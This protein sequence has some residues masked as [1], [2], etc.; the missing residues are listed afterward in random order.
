L[1]LGVLM[2]DDPVTRAL[3]LRT[4]SALEAGF[5]PLPIDQN[6]ARVFA[7]IVAEARRLGRRP[8]IIDSWTAATAV[9]K[10]LRVFTQDKDFEQIPQV[11]VVLV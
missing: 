5:D 9:A 2:A 1:T 11:H 7:E 4:L 10:G 3:R 6:V 8:G